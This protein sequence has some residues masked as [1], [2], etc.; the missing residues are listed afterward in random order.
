M[1]S[2]NVNKIKTFSSVNINNLAFSDIPQDLINALIATEDRNFFKHK[3]LDYTGILRAIFVN[4]KSGYIKQGGSTIT[5]QLS[6]MILNDNKKTFKRK[7]KELI[8][9]KQIEKYLTKQDILTLYLT[10]SYFGAGK[11]GIKEASRFYFDKEV[12][13]LQLEE[14]AMLVGL[15]KAPS[16]YNPTINEELTRS[17]TIQV[18]LNMQKVGFINENDMLSYMVSDI[19]LNTY[20]QSKRDNQNYYF[21]DWVYSQLKDYNI[22]DDIVELSIVTTL[23]E[24]IQN[25]TISAVSEFVEDNKGKIGNAELAVIVMNK[26][27]EILAMVGG[28]NYSKSQFNRSIFANRQTGS[29]FKLFVYLAGFENGLK[30][31]D[32]FIDEP[33]KIFDWYPENNNSKYHGKITVKE[34]FSLSSN[35]VAVQIADYFGIKEIIKNAKKLGLTTNF[36]NDLTISLGSQESNLLEMTTAY[37]TIVNNGIPI[38]PYNVKYITSNNKVIYKRNVSEKSPIF[39][40]KTIENM[41]YLLYLV[42]KEGTGRS[43]RI[44]DLIDKTEAYNATHSDNKFFI[45]GKTGSTQ[46]SKDAWFVGFANDLIIGIWFGND[47]NSPT[48]KIMGGN[49]PSQLWK[50]IME[51]II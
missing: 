16:R 42:V 35:S 19:N 23:N 39:K 7:F 40:T 20:K 1:Y 43:A 47:D 38:F 2:N 3:G 21:A 8:L 18:I 30:I 51:R 24:F 50:M 12:E 44:N 26:N 36:K 49:L 41:Q 11:Y 32:I 9:T 27:G 29:L 13:E 15:L 28:K 31:N 34:A 37:A 4:F 25:R 10:K 5:Q 48:N 17:R 33:I 45:G 46:N 6:K 22:D 14:C